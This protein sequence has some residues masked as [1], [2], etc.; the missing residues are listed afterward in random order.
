VLLGPGG[1]ERKVVSGRASSFQDVH[2]R[3]SMH[4]RFR[5]YIVVS[6]CIVVSG[7]TSSFQGVHRCG[8][9][10][11]C[12]ARLCL[13]G[14]S[15]LRMGCAL[16][17]GFAPGLWAKGRTKGAAQISVNSSGE[18]EPRLTSGG[19]AATFNAL[20]GLFVQSS[21]PCNDPIQETSDQRGRTRKRNALGR[22]ASW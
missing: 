5:T 18:A 9:A 14:H 20:K 4:R 1:F 22:F 11:G 16:G 8:F 17:S 6:A 12:E 3:F 15:R 13:A 2:R 10:A 21:A 7:R 19:E